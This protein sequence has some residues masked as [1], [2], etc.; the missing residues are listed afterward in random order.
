VEKPRRFQHP[1]Q[2]PKSSRRSHRLDPLVVDQAGEVGRVFKDD[3]RVHSP[4][5]EAFVHHAITNKI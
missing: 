2:H 1:A 3:V 4:A 5:L